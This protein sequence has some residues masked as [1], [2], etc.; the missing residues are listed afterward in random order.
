MIFVILP[1]P[2]LPT[3]NRAEFSST[4]AG[5]SRLRDSEASVVQ[6]L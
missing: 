4:V 1:T 6:A 5:D 3:M 2:M